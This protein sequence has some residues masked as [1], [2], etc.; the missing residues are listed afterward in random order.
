MEW[1]SGLPVDAAWVAAEL[2]EEAPLRQRYAL[3]QLAELRLSAA[4]KGRLELVAR[5]LGGRRWTTP[6]PAAAVDSLQRYLDRVDGRLSAIAAVG[7]PARHEIGARLLGLVAPR[8]GILPG[9]SWVV[10]ILGVVGLARP[11]RRSLAALGVAALGSIPFLLASRT[12]TTPLGLVA[13]AAVLPAIV[14]ALALRLAVSWR[15]AAGDQPDFG[16]AAWCLGFGPVLLLV[17]LLIT[18]GASVVRGQQLAA[19]F[20]SAT[21]APLALAG[22]LAGQRRR[23]RWASLLPPASGC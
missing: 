18:D 22:W 19:A 20:P 17:A 8:R 9:V 15:E 3:E 16:W 2:V 10:S 7:A 12:A 11:S 23:R 1:L 6:V 5:D 4:P 13:G 21:V 14:G